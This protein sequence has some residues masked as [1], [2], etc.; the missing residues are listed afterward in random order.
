MVRIIKQKL[1]ILQSGQTNPLMLLLIAVLA[2]MIVLVV[3][4]GVN[5]LNEDIAESTLTGKGYVVLSAGEYTSISDKLDAIKIDAE[6][7]VANAEA[8]VVAAQAAV[9]LVELFNSA[10]RYVFPDSTAR[11]VLFASSDNDTFGAWAEI[12]DNTA[13]TLSSKFAANA[14]YIIDLYLYDLTRADTMW[15]IEIAYGATKTNVARVMFNSDYMNIAKIRSTRIPAG[16]TIYYRMMANCAPTEYLSV[17][18]RYIF[19]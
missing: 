3:I 12:Q 13:T 10:E 16:E 6:A 17:G 2:V 7:A 5:V 9:E 1:K 4:E 19:E 11:Y 18:F 15:L 14:G 8:A